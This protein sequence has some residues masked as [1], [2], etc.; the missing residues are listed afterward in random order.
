M[1]AREKASGEPIKAVGA[2]VHAIGPLTPF[3]EWLRDTPG[4][5]GVTVQRLGLHCP[6]CGGQLK[7][8]EPKKRRKT[9]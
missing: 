4:L 9:P 8:G 2:V 5:R 7:A 6:H 1:K 3:E